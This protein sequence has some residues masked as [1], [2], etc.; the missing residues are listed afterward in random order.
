MICRLI[1][2]MEVASEYVTNWE[3][4][5]RDEK[6]EPLKTKHPVYL[7]ILQKNFDCVVLSLVFSLHRFCNSEMIDCTLDYNKRNCLAVS[8]AY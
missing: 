8:G 1:L 7:K 6:K 2:K 3:V 4:K 5:L